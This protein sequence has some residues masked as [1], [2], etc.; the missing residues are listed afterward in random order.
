MG[1]ILEMRNITKD[2]S[3]VRALDHVNFTVQKGEI[4]CLVGENGAGKST[5]MK[6]LSGV[7][8]KGEYQGDIVL[9]DEI[10]N[11]HSVRDS[12]NHGIGIIHQELALIPELSVYENMFLGHEI[13]RGTF[14]DWNETITKCIKYLDMVNLKVEPEEKIKN[15][16]MGKRQLVEI[17]KAL[18]KNLKVLILDEPTSALNDEESGNL[19]RLLLDLKNHDVTSIM[20]SHKLKEVLE[21]ADTVTVLR[22]GKTICS[23]DK[24]KGEINTQIII[25]NMVGREINDVFPKREARIPGEIVLEVKNLN[26]F[27]KESKHQ[28]VK[29][30]SIIVREGEVV[31]IAG[32]MGAGRTELALSIFGNTMD[33][34][35]T[36]E[37]HID[38][39][40]VDTSSPTKAIENG[41]AY[42][43]EDRKGKGLILIQDIKQ[44]ISLANLQ[45]ITKNLFI[46]ENEEINVAHSYKDSINIKSYSIEQRTGSLSGGNQQKVSLSKWLFTKPR[47]LILDEPTRGIDVGAKFE[48]YT[49]I[50]RLVKEGMSIILIS[51]EL[52]EVMGM[53][54]RIYVVNHGRI[55]GEVLTSKTTPEEIMELATN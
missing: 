33:Y 13:K 54:D 35:L 53:S 48:I 2:F 46:N 15:L 29:D 25:K 34:A 51:S 41:I 6:I 31:G 52:P 36:G 11:F 27:S 19:L 21:I 9:S 28:V 55:S 14:I 50:N 44:N 20:I 1:N 7:Y 10:M 24:D 32:L 5:L 16:G 8:K 4:H 17:A 22:D 26:G 40:K 47:L 3:G 49:I 39:K 23:L 38:G 18:S 42:V 30:A 37:I 12:E 45:S 43:T